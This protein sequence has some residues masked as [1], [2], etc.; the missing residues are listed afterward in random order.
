MARR[1]LLEQIQAGSSLQTVEIVEIHQIS[2]GDLLVRT[3]TEAV[4]R[5]LEED[6]TWLE[7]ITLSVYIKWKTYTVAAYSIQVANINTIVQASTIAALLQQNHS[8][9][10]EL[11]VKKLTWPKSAKR[12]HMLSLHIDTHNTAATNQLIDKGLLEDLKVYTCEV[13]NC[14]AR[15]TQCFHCQAYSYVVR[16]CHSTAKCTFCTGDYTTHK[17]RKAKD[18]LKVK[19]ANCC[20]VRHVV[21]MKV[22]SIQDWELEQLKIVCLNTL[23]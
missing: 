11:T 7:Q 13:F 20:Q 8:L 3:Q 16:A 15:L 21:W 22:C 14:T 2:S 4:W 1:E 12:K 5:S 23:V 19:C 6:T 18:F 9:H 17:C 10:S